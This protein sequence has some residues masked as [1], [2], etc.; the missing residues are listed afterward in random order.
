MGG[1]PAAELRV[2]HDRVNE[3]AV[4]PRHRR[5]ITTLRTPQKTTMRVHNVAG[6]SRRHTVEL[7]VCAEPAMTKQELSASPVSRLAHRKDTSESDLWP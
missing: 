5:T 2:R 6:V 4:S 7:G 3:E 1:P